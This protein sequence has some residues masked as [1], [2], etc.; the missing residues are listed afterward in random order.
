MPSDIGLDASFYNMLDYKGMR[1]KTGE[2]NSIE[3]YITML[4]LPIQF[5]KS[6]GLQ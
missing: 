4:R 5:S 2:V 6:A 3:A 1:E